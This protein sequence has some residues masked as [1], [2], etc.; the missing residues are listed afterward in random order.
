MTDDERFPR[1]YRASHRKYDPR[2]WTGRDTLLTLL[3]LATAAG[4]VALCVFMSR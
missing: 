2:R 4:W 1:D 3:G